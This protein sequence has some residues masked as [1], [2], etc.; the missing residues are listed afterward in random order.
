[1]ASPVDTSVKHFLST[2]A[3]APVVTGAAGTGIALLDAVLVNGFDS[4]TLVS[5]VVLGGLATATFTGGTH[6]AGIDAVV[7][8][9][10]VTGSL[11]ALN[12]EQKVVSTTSTT[13][14]F[15]TAAANGTATGTI[16]MKLAPLG[17]TKVYSG[18]NKAVYRSGDVASAGSYLRVDDTSTTTMRVVAYESMS[19]VDTGTAAFPTDPQV[20]G[21][22]Y[23]IK[24]S[25]A[26]ATAVPWF[27]FGNSLI[28]YPL[29]NFRYTSA[30]GQLGV[31]IQGFGD[32]TSYKVADPY[33]C[34]MIG[35]TVVGGWSGAQ[36]SL[37]SFAN[38]A[39]AY[40]ARSHTGL[41]SS[42]VTLANGSGTAMSGATSTLGPYPSPVDSG[43]ILSPNYCGIS[44]I[45]TNGLRGQYPGF[46]LC[47]QAIGTGAFSIGDKIDGTGDT[48][49][50][51]LYAVY[52]P[53]TNSST[54]VGN[55]MS[56]FDIT[57]PW[58]A[59]F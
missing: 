26:G 15:A 13:V 18:T 33:R 31:P 48:A 40:I 17:W 50:R 29:I 10:G 28:F 21:G 54:S 22:M 8:I 4:R 9:A 3:N 52:T 2:M 27:V 56:F 43:L 41:G 23:W 5:L 51:R 30:V 11:T 19:D 38:S 34:V 37:A 7:T 46:W 6:A 32:L 59:P 53:S 12:G 58:P 35:S 16:T 49:G 36:G 20:T 44:P 25:V 45:S 42:Q 47:P 55:E 57:G 39:G 1:M 14:V 24:A